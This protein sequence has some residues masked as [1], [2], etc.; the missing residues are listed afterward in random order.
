MKL[1]ICIGYILL[2]CIP[3]TNMLNEHF[4]GFPYRIYL[5]FYVNGNPYNNHSWY[6]RN[7]IY[8]IIIFLVLVIVLEVLQIIIAKLNTNRIIEK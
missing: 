7:L 4:W 8:N 3:R 2:N 6:V 5:S 1:I